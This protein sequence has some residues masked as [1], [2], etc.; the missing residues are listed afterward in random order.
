MCGK[1][2]AS[3]SNPLVVEMC[4]RVELGP[5]ALQRLVL[6]GKNKGASQQNLTVLPTPAQA[7]TR[8]C[9]LPQ[10]PLRLHAA[11]GPRPPK[12]KGL[13]PPLPSFPLC[14]GDTHPL[15]S[16]GGDAWLTLTLHRAGSA[17]RH[18]ERLPWGGGCWGQSTFFFTLVTHKDKGQAE[19]T[20]ILRAG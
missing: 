7:W 18:S 15:A 1:I 14:Q 12:H 4:T 3:C 2:H 10:S 8:D 13:S 9:N 16:R 6:G 17:T 5:P 19:G 20:G 11:T